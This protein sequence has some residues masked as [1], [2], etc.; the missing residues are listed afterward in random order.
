M[1]NVEG[2]YVICELIYRYMIILK[3]WESIEIISCYL[4]VYS[5]SLLL[6]HSWDKGVYRL[7]TEQYYYELRFAIVIFTVIIYS[8]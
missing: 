5:K 8:K 2:K 1:A 4:S 3:N 7:T 6:E